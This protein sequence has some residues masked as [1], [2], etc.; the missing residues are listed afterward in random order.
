MNLK[1][2]GFLVPGYD[3]DLV[4]FNKDCEILGTIINGTPQHLK[5]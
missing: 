1:N 2:K 5:F 3:A 4:I